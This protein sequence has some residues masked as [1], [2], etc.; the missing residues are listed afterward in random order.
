[1][2]GLIDRVGPGFEGSKSQI[3]K[4]TKEAQKYILGTNSDLR[5]LFR[6]FP[7][8]KIF[9]V[10]EIWSILWSKIMFFYNQPIQLLLAPRQKYF[11]SNSTSILGLG[12]KYRAG[13]GWC[14]PEKSRKTQKIAKIAVVDFR[15]LFLYFSFKIHANL[16]N[17]RL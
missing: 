8:P 9:Q 3:F 6:V 13:A 1:M 12:K 7:R 17:F 16:L 15:V 14:W 11:L 4:A 2:M 10:F 5:I